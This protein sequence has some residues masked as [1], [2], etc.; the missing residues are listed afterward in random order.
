M[1][2]LPTSRPSDAEA[3]VGR[4]AEASRRFAA[5]ELVDLAELAETVE[6][7]ARQ[8]D[9]SNTDTVYVLMAL[10]DELQRLAE[11]VDRQRRQARGTIT[12]IEQARRARH[13]YQRRK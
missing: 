8:A 3:A 13:A 6:R 11:A 12:D 2:P 10:Q 5:G 4:I 1:T 7:V 9:R